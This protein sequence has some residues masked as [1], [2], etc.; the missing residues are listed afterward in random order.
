ML[1]ILTSVKVNIDK[2]HW[3]ILGDKL[4]TVFI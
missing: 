1:F 3:I 4:Q 2:K